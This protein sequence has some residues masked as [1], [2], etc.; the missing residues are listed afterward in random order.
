M[1]CLKV[2]PFCKNWFLKWFFFLSSAWHQ[3][4]SGQCLSLYV[5]MEKH[6][7]QMYVNPVTVK[8][9]EICKH[10]W[11]LVICPSPPCITSPHIKI[12]ILWKQFW[13]RI[14]NFLLCYFSL[15][16]TPSLLNDDSSFWAYHFDAP[17]LIA[18]C[19]INSKHSNHQAFTRTF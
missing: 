1:L 12:N 5:Y 10:D 14:C 7:L 2:F 9:L 19:S 15:K 18:S 6:H 16:E 8:K 13:L 11:Q 3:K 4:L 17:S